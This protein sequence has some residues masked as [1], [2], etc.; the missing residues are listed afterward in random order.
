MSKTL[1]NKIFKSVAIVTLFA[2]MTR[3]LSFLFKIYLSRAYGAETVGLYQICLSVLLLL[4]SI[5]VGGMPTVLSRKIAEAE[6]YKNFKKQNALTLASI[7]IGLVISGIIIVICFLMRSHLNLI[8]SDS[9]AGNLF[10]IM[11]PA[12]ISSTIYCSIRAFLMGK[13]KFFAFSATELLEEILKIIFTVLFA[14]CAVSWISGATAIAVAFLIADCVCALAL[15]VIFF[16]SG[17]RLAKPQGFLEL[18]KS[19]LPLTTL[20]ISTGLVASLTAIVVPLMLTKNGLDTSVATAL[21]GKVSGMALPLITAPTTI[22][23]SLAIVLLPDMAKANVL[24][25]NEDIEN[26]LSYSLIF[27]TFV[28]SLFFIAFTSLGEEIGTLFFGDK[29]AGYFVKTC[30]S[31]MFFI[32]TNQTITPVLNSLGLE[33]KTLRNYVIGLV[34]F[35]PCILFLPKLVGIYAIAIANGVMLLTSCILSFATIKKRNIKI[36]F[37]LRN[38][39][40]IALTAP[41][42]LLSNFL[43]G[44]LKNYLT[45][46]FVILFCAIICIGMFALLIFTLKIMPV[47][48]SFKIKRKRKA[49]SEKIACKSKSKKKLQL[50]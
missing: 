13:K 9:R 21:Y 49:N 3:V 8:F 19:S 16:T 23:S 30:A 40:I 46:F 38:V 24:S 10:L 42:I 15:T 48:F 28:C 22:I 31:L 1:N 34:L 25:D 50:S 32:G 39:L 12:L 44:I 29:D 20:R 18:T 2:V 33:N 14:T 45:D 36:K 47:N 6:T 43:R 17:G 27:S 11:L 35:V 26:K 5:S 37:K 41:C 4:L 7:I